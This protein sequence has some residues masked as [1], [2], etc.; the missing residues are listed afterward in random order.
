MI[1]KSSARNAMLAVIAIAWPGQASLPKTNAVVIQNSGQAVTSHSSESTVAPEAKV[2]IAS[3]RLSFEDEMRRLSEQS[4]CTIIAEGVPLNA[5]RDSPQ[6]SVGEAQP[7]AVGLETIIRVADA[8]D[9]DAESISGHLIVLRK[10]YSDENDLPCVTYDEAE[11]SLRSILGLIGDYANL[12]A[13]TQQDTGKLYLSLTAEQRAR[14]VSGI[15]VTDLSEEQTRL[16]RSIA[17]YFWSVTNCVQLRQAE[18]LLAGIKSPKTAFVWLSIAPLHVDAFGFRGPIY[19]RGVVRDCP[20]D[21]RFRLTTS[22]YERTSNKDYPNLATLRTDASKGL[23][24]S[25]QQDPDPT[26]PTEID[27]KLAAGMLANRLPSTRTL[28]ELC[29]EWTAGKLGSSGLGGKSEI[30]HAEVGKEIGGKP[31]SLFGSEYSSAGQ[32]VRAVAALYGLQLLAPKEGEYHLIL[33][34]PVQPESAEDFPRQ[35]ER[36]IP[37][38]LIRQAAGLSAAAAKSVASKSGPLPDVALAPTAT[39]RARIHAEAQQRLL[40]SDAIAGNAGY[41]PEARRLLLLAKP[42]VPTKNSPPVRVMDANPEV[43]RLIA[44]MMYSSGIC[45]TEVKALTSRPLPDYMFHGDD[46]MFKAK[47][48][49]DGTG[50]SWDFGEADANGVFLSEGGFAMQLPPN[51]S[52]Q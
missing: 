49:K 38:P 48:Y 39:D 17:A 37:A 41:Y 28:E 9:Y 25:A 50:A 36:L 14:A 51:A 32:Q 7:A 52:A 2:H 13:A 23:P 16:A 6:Q 1:M 22:G 4:H 40:Q 29:Q 21:N 5:E 20:L 35:I 45:R 24:D 44:L 42:L 10:R 31:V 3:H 34:I 19:L 12:D 46:L 43:R 47:L 18:A 15:H 30:V 33:P 11:H 8:F 27:R 26:D